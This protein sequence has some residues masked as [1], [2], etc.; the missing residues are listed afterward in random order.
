M[1]REFNK[2][3]LSVYIDENGQQKIICPT[4]EDIP[5]LT[6]TDVN[7]R[8]GN[9]VECVADLIVNL[10]EGKKLKNALSVSLSSSIVFE[11]PSGEIVPGITSQT[12]NCDPTGFAT[13]SITM[14][15][16]L[17]STRQKALDLYLS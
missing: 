10:P 1:K 7:D 5:Y 3:L 8:V 14:Q 11:L 6:Y 12:L 4:G 2:D 13:A 9:P 15:V 17:V 16:N